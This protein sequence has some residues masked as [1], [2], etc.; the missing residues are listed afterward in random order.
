[1]ISFSFIVLWIYFLNLLCKERQMCV[2]NLPK[3]VT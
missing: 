3:V 2:N 1:M